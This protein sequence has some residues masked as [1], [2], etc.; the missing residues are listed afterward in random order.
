MNQQAEIALF[1]QGWIE[2]M[3][4]QMRVQHIIFAL[5]VT[6]LLVSGLALHFAD[7]AV[8]QFLVMILGG[9][10][11]RGIVHRVAAIG[12]IGITLYHAW[13]NLFTKEGR[14]EFWQRLLERRDIDNAVQTIR[15]NLGKVPARPR[16]ARYTPGQKLHYWIAGF[17]IITMMASGLILWNPT[18]AMSA[19]PRPVV[20]ILAVIHGSEGYLAFVILVLWHLYDVHLSPRNF[21]MSRVW[22]DGKMSVE[23]ARELHPLEHDRV[24][25]MVQSD[26]EK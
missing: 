2:R 26:E 25:G 22:L 15:F 1:R 20:E 6:L 24:K 9:F 12:L 14:K 10:E 23:R 11:M 8:G 4:P 21:P 5:C 13:Y 19:L 3:T 18:L 16:I 7:N 17:F